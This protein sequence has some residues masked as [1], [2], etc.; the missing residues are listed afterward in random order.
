MEG[1]L[2]DGAENYTETP[3]QLAS[4]AGSPASLTNKYFRALHQHRGVLLVLC[5]LL[6]EGAQCEFSYLSG[7]FKVDIISFKGLLGCKERGFCG[8]EMLII[9]L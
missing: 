7:A 2:Q 1:A 8:I 9:D 6:P 4:A 5:I 3:L